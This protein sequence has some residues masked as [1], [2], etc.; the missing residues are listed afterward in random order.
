MSSC[1]DKVFAS[2]SRLVV[3]LVCC[4]VFCATLS[5]CGNTWQNIKRIITPNS[6]AEVSEEIRKT[7]ALT[8][9]EK[10]AVELQGVKQQEQP[11]AIAAQS[12]KQA[13]VAVA[14]QSKPVK[15]VKHQGSIS[16]NI[17]LLGKD[18]TQISAEGLILRLSRVDGESIRSV[19][20]G[21]QNHT[22]DMKNKQYLPRYLSIN[23]G[24]TLSFVNKDT[25]KHNVF[26]STGDN[27]FDLGT[28]DGGLERDVTLYEDG[29][30]KVYCNI[31]RNMALF[32]SVDDTSRTAMATAE[33]DFSFDALP[34][35]DYELNIWHIRGQKTLAVR[36]ENNKELTLTEVLDTTRFK[37]TPHSNKFGEK[38]SVKKNRYGSSSR[39][40][41]D[42]EFF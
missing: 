19:G 14:K 34:A 33:G 15:P 32:V 30:V 38:Y 2:C 8:P 18:Q 6:T 37:Y 9:Q 26:S 28:Y 22:V 7:D 23:S 42:D 3:K 29:L 36:V 13:P 20:E 27:A 31:H 35:G 21:S 17:R 25:I 4:T 12:V 1:S 24:D 39:G 16:G 5:A 40:G 11:V 41:I 10:S